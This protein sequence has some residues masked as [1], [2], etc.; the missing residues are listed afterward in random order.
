MPAYTWVKS[1]GV[2]N[3]NDDTCWSPVGVP[4]AGASDSVTIPATSPSDG[5]AIANDDFTDTDGTALESHTADSG[6]TWTKHTASA[7]GATINSNKLAGNLNTTAALYYASAVPA[8][9][10]Y[11]VQAT[12]TLT[13]AAS[14]LSGIAGRMDTT[15]QTFYLLRYNGADYQLYKF[16]AG[17]ATVIGSYTAAESNGAVR[18]LKLVMFGTSIYGYVD[19]VLR[20]AVTDSAITAAGRA[21]VRLGNTATI[22]SLDTWSSFQIT[23]VASVATYNY[24]NTANA[25]TGLVINGTLTASTTAGTY[26]LKMAGNITGAGTF[27][28]G[29][30]GTPYPTDCQFNIVFTGAQNITMT[31]SASLQFYC[32]QPTLLGG[33]L[34]SSTAKSIVSIT[35]ASVAVVTCTAHGFSN[36]N[37]VYLANVGGMV[38]L[39]N[40]KF[41]VNNVTANTFELRWFDT[42]VNVDSTNFTTYTSG[43]LVCPDQ[44]EAATATAL[45][46]DAD[47]SADLV[48]TSTLGSKLVRIVNV[49]RAMD[50]EE[51]TISS[52]SSTQI[53]VTAGLTAAKKS[54]AKLYLINRNIRITGSTAVGIVILG[55]TTGAVLNVEFSGNGGNSIAVSAGLTGACTFNGTMSGTSGGAQYGVY[56]QRGGTIAGVMCGLS[57]QAIL[58]A[59]QGTVINGVIAGCA[60]AVSGCYNVS[61]SASIYGCSTAILNNYGSVFS[62]DMYGSATSFSAFNNSEISGFVKNSATP[63]NTCHKLAI[64][65][66]IHNGLQVTL[67]S[68]IEVYGTLRGQTAPQFLTDI[69]YRG[70]LLEGNTNDI[71]VTSTQYA[72]IRA[73]RTNFNSPTKISTVY[74]QVAAA[75][76]PVLILNVDPVISGVVKEGRLQGW[77]PGGTITNNESPPASP[78]VALSFTHLFTFQSTATTTFPG[79]ITY[80]VF[81]DIPVM[82]IA[83]VLLSIDV[84]LK[85][86]LNSMGETPRVQL[87]DPGQPWDSVASK[88]VDTAMADDTNWQTITVSTTPTVNKQYILRVRGRHTSGTLDWNYAIASSGGGLFAPSSINGG[89]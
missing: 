62:G 56:Q 13:T 19:G 79:S 34:I 64:T 12:V 30:S 39:S 83:G 70:A 9:A 29:S 45:T 80:P 57:Q 52:I 59:F 5:T 40:Q 17:T 15:A 65:G 8:S 54:G 72:P 41:L 6:A 60:N 77:T 63:I 48:W 82:G 86:S 49:N 44:A 10:D 7:T 51:R 66:T 75:S 2:G 31:G 23:A 21:G 25:L 42:S 74:N 4:G 36:G 53:T 43:G 69:V 24:D 18:V 58:Q 88:I 46:I 67:S 16:V 84:Y 22:D 28:I 85:K 37:T 26:V 1:G 27:N 50:T 81:V 76:G 89:I 55:T 78:P 11:A 61:I 32:A 73:Y 68:G 20:I 3:W 71:Y 87:I 38:E 33:Q 35:K 47:V 14:A